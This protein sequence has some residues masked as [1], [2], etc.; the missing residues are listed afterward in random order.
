MKLTEAKLKQMILETMQRS[1]NY[2]KLKTLMVTSEGYLQAE[3]LYEMLRGTF[4]E[5]EQ[6]QMDIFFKPLFIMRE[7]IKLE[8]K[9]NQAKKEYEKFYEMIFQRS[10]N[11][12]TAE[13]DNI[14]HDLFRQ[15]DLAEA[16]LMDKNDELHRS[17][18]ILESNAERHP[19]EAPEDIMTVVSDALWTTL[20]GSPRTKS[21]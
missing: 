10:D 21:R 9:Y 4:D 3:S 11:Q 7:R 19:S 17:Y 14:L 12:V 20:T 2:E 1:A 8:E 6:M 16:E 18:D 13:E 15:V 5:E